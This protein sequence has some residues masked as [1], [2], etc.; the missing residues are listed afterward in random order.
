MGHELQLPLL[1]YLFCWQEQA[2]IEVDPAELVEP[3]GHELQ[4]PLFKYL[5]EPQ[6]HAL[7]EVDP[8][9]LVEPQKQS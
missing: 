6:V 8:A 5:F 4:L 1:K 3:L 9:G 2:L 7:I